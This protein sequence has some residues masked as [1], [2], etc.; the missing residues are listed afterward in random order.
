VNRLVY[1]Y[2][3]KEAEMNAKMNYMVNQD[4]VSNLEKLLVKEATAVS[5]LHE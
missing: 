3:Q 1:I 5:K 4:V 2:Q